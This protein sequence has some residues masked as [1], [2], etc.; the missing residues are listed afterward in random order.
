VISHCK[1]CR[2]ESGQGTDGSDFYAGAVLLNDKGEEVKPDAILYNAEGQAVNIYDAFFQR[3]SREE[4]KSPDFQ[5]IG[6]ALMSNC[7]GARMETGKDPSIAYCTQCDQPRAML[8]EKQDGWV[9]YVESAIPV[10][11]PFVV[12]EL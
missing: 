7:C 12:P 1:T 8:N 9:N 3:G 6:G 11:K 4:N 10:E 5:M 2:C